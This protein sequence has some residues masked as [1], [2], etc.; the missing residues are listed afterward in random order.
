MPNEL[1][2]FI[3]YTSNIGNINIQVF[4]EDDTVWTTQK[5]MADIFGTSRENVTAHLKNIFQDKEL[6]EN[7]VCKKILHTAADGKKYNTNYYNLDAILSVGYRVNS[8]QA[9][10][11]RKWAN[12]VLKEY[13]IK[14]FAL[15]DDRLKQG[16]QLFNKDYFD[17]LLERIREIRASERLFYK[18]ITDIYADCSID[19]DKD[20]EITHEFYATVQNKLHFAIH[21]HTAAELIYER[22]NAKKPKMGLTSWENE[23]GGGKIL[24]SDTLTAKNY[25]NEQEISELNR[26]VNMYLDYAE[27]QAK[28]Q[29]PMKMADWVEKLDAFL[30]F[31]EYDILKNAGKISKKVAEELA[32]EEYK[33]FRVIQDKEFV[34][35]FDKVIEKI[36][37]KNK[38]LKRGDDE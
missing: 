25:L 28:R 27:N 22:V 16:A 3:L 18:K 8:M 37:A 4:I 7:S 34:S 21:G 31:N 26:V 17:E 20:A 9:T 23:R 2:K 24:Q 33:K 19:Y 1:S 35:D 30:Q 14:G 5:G 32:K 12:S 11:F 15:D 6:Q 38:L 13:L 10:Q 36:K 29:L